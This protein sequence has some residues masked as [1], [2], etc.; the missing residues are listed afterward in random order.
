MK[1]RELPKGTACGHHE[2]QVVFIV[3]QENAC[4][5]LGEGQGRRLQFKVKNLNGFKVV[6]P[7]GELEED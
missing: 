3:T 1:L 6:S 7:Y 2:L 4:I 5:S